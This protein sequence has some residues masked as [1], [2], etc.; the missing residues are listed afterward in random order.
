M[1]KYRKNLDTYCFYFIVIRLSDFI[2]INVY[3][4]NMDVNM[5][6]CANCKIEKPISEF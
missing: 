5:K 4:I 6:R 2:E 3:Y 1:A